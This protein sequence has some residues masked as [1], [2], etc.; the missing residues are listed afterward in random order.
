MKGYR[1]LPCGDAAVTVE[2]E[3]GISPQTNACVRRLSDKLAGLGVHGITATIPAYC[4]LCVC[5]SPA[6]LSQKKVIK[7]LDK[8]CSDMDDESN[9]SCGAVLFRIPVCYGGAFGED[10]SNVARHASISVDEVIRLHTEPEYLVYML[11]FLPG[12]AYLGGLDSRLHT[13][14]LDSPRTKI[15]AGSVGIGGEQTGVYPIA[16]PGGWQLIGRTPI[17]LYDPNAD[18]P[19]LLSAGDRI[20]FYSI[21]PEEFSEIEDKLRCGKY[22]IER[23]EAGL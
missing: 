1:I 19:V 16:S 15:P 7:L 2:L 4:S 9:S 3:G 13:P 18:A 20:K 10:I 21:T 5:Y 11:G 23:E 17:P 12:F 22:V 14:R 8:L 6:R